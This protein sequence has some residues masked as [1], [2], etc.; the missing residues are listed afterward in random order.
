[1]TVPAFAVRRTHS[2]SHQEKRLPG[3]RYGRGRSEPRMAWLIIGSS[4]PYGLI[5]K[6]QPLMDLLITQAVS[7]S[8]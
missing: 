7:K 6:K 8:V 3:L 5:S 4:E 1:M 2:D